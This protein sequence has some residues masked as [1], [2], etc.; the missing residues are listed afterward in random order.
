MPRRPRA[1]QGIGGIEE[2][3]TPEEIKMLGELRPGA[4]YALRCVEQL[5]REVLLK[6]AEQLNELSKHGFR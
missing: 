5:P 6:Y 1:E 4:T 2:T 3:V